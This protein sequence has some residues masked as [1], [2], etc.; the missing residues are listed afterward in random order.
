MQLGKISPEPV[1]LVPC[2]RVTLT[3]GEIVGNAERISTT[4]NWKYE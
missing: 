2:A 3:T 1:Q 4:F